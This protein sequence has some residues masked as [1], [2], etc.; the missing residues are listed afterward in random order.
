MRRSV[1]APRK[2]I[3]DRRSQRGERCMPAAPC[4]RVAYTRTAVPRFY[5]CDAR[6]CCTIANRAAVRR[7]DGL[8]W[9]GAVTHSAVAVECLLSMSSCTKLISMRR[10]SSS[11]FACLLQHSTACC[12]PVQPVC[13]AIQH[14]CHTSS[15]SCGGCTAR[16]MNE[17][18]SSTWRPAHVTSGAQRHARAADSESAWQNATCGDVRVRRASALTTGLR[19]WTGVPLQL[20]GLLPY[21]AC[22]AL[23][24]RCKAAFRVL[25][26]GAALVVSCTLSGAKDLM[27]HPP[28]KGA[29][30]MCILYGARMPL[31]VCSLPRCA[32]PRSVRAACAGRAGPSKTQAL[33]CRR[34]QPCPISTRHFDASLKKGSRCHRAHH[35]DTKKPTKSDANMRKQSQQP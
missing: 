4:R 26:S 5:R 24:L 9:H 10:P 17:R 22:Q 25:H 12:I 7:R 1:C 19:G 11:A 15:S 20:R 23:L 8:G 18:S 2:L 35:Y 29:Q 13:N 27:Q 31:V 28:G 6:A 14:V 32:G 3:T 34:P 30:R 16:C 21:R 33:T